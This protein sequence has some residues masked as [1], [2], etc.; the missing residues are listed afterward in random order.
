MKGALKEIN[1]ESH[2]STV[3]MVK[4]TQRGGDN[5]SMDFLNGNLK[6]FGERHLR[7]KLLG[8]SDNHAICEALQRRSFFLP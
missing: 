7:K 1:F 3:R 6:A 8:I 4:K 2:V 5:M